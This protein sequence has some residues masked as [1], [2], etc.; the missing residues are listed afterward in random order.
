MMSLT[1][2]PAVPNVVPLPFALG[3]VQFYGLLTS[4]AFDVAKLL[5][6]DNFNYLLKRVSV[7]FGMSTNNTILW[8]GPNPYQIANL[9]T[10]NPTISFNFD[11]KSGEYDDLCFNSTCVWDLK[12]STSSPTRKMLYL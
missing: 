3:N 9:T 2:N 7:N 8:N 5:P 11:S 12:P 1:T 6:S 10:M 4:F